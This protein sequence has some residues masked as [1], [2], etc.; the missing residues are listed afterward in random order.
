MAHAD[1]TSFVVEP[2]TY[3]KVIFT[4]TYVPRPAS[5]PRASAARFL[6]TASLGSCLRPH[7]SFCLFPCR[8]G[9]FDIELWS[10]EAPKTCRNFVQHCLDGYYVGSKFFYVMSEFLA[11]AGDPTNTG[12]GGATA[13][14]QPLPDEVS[15]RSTLSFARRGLLGMWKVGAKLETEK[16]RAGVVR[17]AEKAGASRSAA[18]ASAGATG[19]VAGS[20][21]FLTL[22]ACP[23]LDKAFTVRAVRGQRARERKGLHVCLCARLSAIPR[24]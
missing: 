11:V 2:P 8:I 10:K 5:C 24:S 20:Q 17:A 21:F 19:G 23:F 18:Q 3:G 4:T 16:H 9:D 7:P 6:F 14:G 13:D 15:K 1:P 12:A 22:A